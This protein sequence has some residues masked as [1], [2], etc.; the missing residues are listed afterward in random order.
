MKLPQTPTVAVTRA[1]AAIRLRT[2]VLRRTGRSDEGAAGTELVAERQHSGGRRF[3][4]S[5]GESEGQSPSDEK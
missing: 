5:A 3:K 4:R 2:S 1:S